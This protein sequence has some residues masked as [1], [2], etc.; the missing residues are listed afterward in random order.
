[1]VILGPDL[2]LIF[3]LSPVVV[4]NVIAGVW[5]LRKERR[6]LQVYFLLTDYEKDY[7]LYSN[8]IVRIHGICR[9]QIP[10]KQ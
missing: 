2:K 9:M 5:G 7:L 8:I 3:P 6:F 10:K 4:W 1:M